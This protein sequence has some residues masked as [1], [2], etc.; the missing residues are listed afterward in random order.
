M[1][2]IKFLLRMMHLAALVIGA[3]LILAAVA[4][5]FYCAW[6]VVTGQI[7]VKNNY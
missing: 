2:L 1:D 5:L 3:F 4:G 7:F 6:E